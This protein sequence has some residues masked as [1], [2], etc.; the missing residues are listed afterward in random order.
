MDAIQQKKSRFE[1]AVKKSKFIIKN[2]W[3]LLGLGILYLLFGMWVLRTPASAYMTLVIFFAAFMFVSG[4]SS[5]V[6]AI[7]N[8]DK[9]DD[10]GWHLTGAIFD[11]VV[12]CILFFY[13]GIT[14]AVLPVLVAFYFMMKGFATL[15]LATDM[16]RYGEEKWGWLLVSGLL[17]TTFAVLIIFNPALGGFTIIVFTALALFSLGFFNIGLSLSLRK[18]A[19]VGEELRTSHTLD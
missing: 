6:F 19:K 18:L 14:M 2:W 5:L 12:G 10:W 1:S 3:L 11:F 16:R 8:K 13:P 9:I 15:G 17:S 7:A 4:I